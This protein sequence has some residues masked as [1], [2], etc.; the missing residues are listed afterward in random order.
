[1]SQYLTAMVGA[2]TSVAISLTALARH[3]TAIEPLPRPTGRHRGKPEA[4]LVP[5]A[6]L[7]RPRESLAKFEAYCPAERRMTLHCETRVTSA[8]LC[9]DC[10]N[11]T[12][13]PGEK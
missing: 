12:M 9:L 2:G 8:F 4:E 6:E 13:I 11:T 3:L 1:M 7:F 5:L 10:R